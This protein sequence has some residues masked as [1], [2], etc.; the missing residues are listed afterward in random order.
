MASF[1]ALNFLGMKKFARVSNAITWWK[2]AIPVIAIVVLLFKFHGA[3]FSGH[4]GFMPYGLKALF[5][6]IPSAGIVFAYLGFEQADQLAAEVKNPQRNL[7]LAIILSILIGTAI[8]VLLAGRVHR[9][10]AVERPRTRLGRNYQ[11]RNPT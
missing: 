6:A 1:T 2:I 10:D 8:Y 11:S 9:R 3:N 7:P 4:G 5:G